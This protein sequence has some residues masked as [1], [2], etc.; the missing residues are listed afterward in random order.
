MSS[1]RDLETNKGDQ[2]TLDLYGIDVEPVR[3]SAI[4]RLALPLAL[5]VG[6]AFFIVLMIQFIPGLDSQPPVS[7]FRNV[8]PMDGPDMLKAFMPGGQQSEMMDATLPAPP[9][10]IEVVRE[11]NVLAHTL[12]SDSFQAALVLQVRQILESPTA[13][14]LTALLGEGLPAELEESNQVDL[15]SIETIIV[16]VDSLPAQLAPAGPDAPPAIE[17]EESA[18]EASDPGDQEPAVAEIPLAP[19]PMELAV[20]VKLVEGSDA[21]AIAT[22]LTRSIPGIWREEEIGEKPGR[23]N[24]LPLPPPLPTGICIYDERTLLVSSP[25]SILNMLAAEGSSPLAKRLSTIDLSNDAALVVTPGLLPATIMEGLDG[26][27]LPPLIMIRELPGQLQAAS[28][29]IRLTS[30]PQLQLEFDS[31]DKATAST[32]RNSIQ[33]IL[34]FAE[35]IISVQQDQFVDNPVAP[36][37]YVEMLHALETLVKSK[38]VEQ[39]GLTNVVSVSLSEEI[40]AVLMALPAMMEADDSWTDPDAEAEGEMP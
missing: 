12:V 36:D 38:K 28:V 35:I 19:S 15:E 26:T 34:T 33:G 11:Q 40:I 30:D 27:L 37:G 3:P 18:G 23:V 24:A 7:R 25:A 22:A 21:S 9:L 39:H 13:E 14:P 1:N 4:K 16:L 17:S 31:P 6:V 8:P 29:A 20:I 5:V 32:V 2:E 10:E